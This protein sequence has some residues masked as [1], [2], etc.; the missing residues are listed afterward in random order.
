MTSDLEKANAVNA[1]HLCLAVL[2]VFFFYCFIGTHALEAQF[3][4][5][6]RK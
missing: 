2:C 6:L 1:V 4:T 3:V 5:T